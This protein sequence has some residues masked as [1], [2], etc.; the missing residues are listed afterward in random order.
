MILN[1]DVVIFDEALAGLD[2]STR[3]QIVDLL[4]GLQASG[5]KSYMFITHDLQVAEELT[6]SIL[7]MQNGKITES[8]TFPK[9][10]AAGH[11]NEPKTFT[12]HA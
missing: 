8:S 4:L 1:P 3:S 11:P 5:P 7:V 12:S 10:T 6:N 2:A 9:R